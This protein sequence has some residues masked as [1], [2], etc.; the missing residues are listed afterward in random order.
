[1][2]KLD[3]YILL[4]LSGGYAGNN[5]VWRRAVVGL[6]LA[7]SYFSEI[8]YFASLVY[9]PIFI[10]FYFIFESEYY[11]YISLSILYRNLSG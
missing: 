11:L 9:T 7:S 4:G 8:S 3:N 5:Y 2:A 1:M 6:L 10:L